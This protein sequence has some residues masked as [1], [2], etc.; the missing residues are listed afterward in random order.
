MSETDKD[1]HTYTHTHPTTHTYTYAHICNT[2]N[3]TLTQ[4][5]R[6]TYIEFDQPA[7]DV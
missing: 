2:N 1:T 4:L 3:H 6:Q 5:S 7:F